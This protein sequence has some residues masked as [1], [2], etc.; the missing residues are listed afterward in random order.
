M[1][2]LYPNRMGFIEH[3]LVSGVAEDDFVDNHIDDNQLHYEAFLRSIVPERNL[4]AP[5]GFPKI[6][7]ISRIGL[8]WRYH[9]THGD[10]FVDYSTFYFTLKKIRLEA[11]VGLVSPVRQKITIRVWSY[12]SIDLWCNGE[13]KIVLETPCYKPIMH[14]DAVLDLEEGFNS[15]YVSLI[16]QAAANIHRRLDN[17]IMKTCGN[18]IY[19]S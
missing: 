4:D 7:E 10:S 19:S 16:A 9:F 14:K 2:K 6:G 1:E 18:N 11:A 17:S 3:F 15:I 5:H 12:A 13:R 8:P